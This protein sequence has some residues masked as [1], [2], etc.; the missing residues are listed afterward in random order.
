M[1]RNFRY[2]ILLSLLVSSASCVSNK[3]IVYLQ[4]QERSSG[5]KDF[6]P[7]SFDEVSPD[8][9][10][11]TNDVISVKINHLQLTQD[12]QQVSEEFDTQTRLG[13]QHPMLTGFTIDEKGM[14]DLPTVGEVKLGG[15]N[16]FEAQ[17]AI[18]DKAKSYY[19]NYSVKVFLLNSYVSVLGE[20]GRP[21]R[22]PVYVNELTILEAL[23]M[24]GD[25]TEYADREKV[26]LIRNRGG[27]NEVLVVDLNDRNLLASPAYYL[28]P[29][30]I[31]LVNP[32]KSK[33][34]IR[35]DPQNFF[36]AI[37][38]LVSVATLYVLVTR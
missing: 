11:E 21:G 28:Q 29:N 23:G 37:T 30:D 14:V 24:A 9:I 34:F 3:K 17:R 26:R 2:L 25:A 6:E 31:I 12:F 7:T 20:V 36:N 10:L 13:I 19:T 38:T 1:F 4:D 5:F 33:K 35:R 22:F 18:S 27:K 8:Y 16:L 15:L 32:L